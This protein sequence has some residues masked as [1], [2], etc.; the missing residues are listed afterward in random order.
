MHWVLIDTVIQQPDRPD[1][2]T[3]ITAQRMDQWA[4]SGAQFHQPM[5][6]GPPASAHAA[7]RDFVGDRP[8]VAYD[9][10][11]HLDRVLRPDWQRLGIDPVGNPG[12]CL[13]QLTQR[14]VDPLPITDFSLRTLHQYYAL[15]DP[16]ATSS[17]ADFDRLLQLI[18]HVIGPAAHAK[19][20]T[21][22]PA[23]EAFMAHEWFPSRIAFGRF[24]GRHF[25]EAR[26]DRALHAWLESLAASTSERSATMGQWYLNALETAPADEPLIA[27]E[28]PELEAVRRRVAEARARLADLEAE[29]SYEHSAVSRIEGRVFEALRHEYEQ[30]D[31]L[32][33]LVRYRRSYRDTLIFDGEASAETVAGQFASEQARCREDYHRTA[34]EAASEP[35][36]D[37]DAYAEMQRLYKKLVKL[38]HPDR[39]HADP[40]KQRAYERLTSEINRAR[41]ASDLS[42]LQAISED[43][44][45]YLDALGLQSLDF[46]DDNDVRQLRR[47]HEGLELEILTLIDGINRLRDSQGY[48]LYQL[49]VNRPQALERYI[50][51]QRE[52]LRLEINALQ[53][54]ADDLAAELEALAG[55][56]VF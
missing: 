49:S 44:N 46:G 12:F 27:V 20:L 51:R 39:Y 48:A 41:D 53:G 2:I 5:S 52:D 35:L 19:G 8:L 15:A 25:T 32:V 28:D 3:A 43:P 33:L 40:E 34:A 26:H 6:G 36:P 17:I 56:P 7:L 10:D 30:R 50:E 23:I 38:F 37:D 42:A 45:G 1:R 29:Y 16:E 54:E 47:L 21:D 9:L 24:K 13:L 18:D 55:Y 22:W 11:F 14:L 4:P 31:Q